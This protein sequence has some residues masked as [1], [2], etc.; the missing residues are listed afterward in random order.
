MAIQRGKRGY[1][2]S[3]RDADRKWFPRL[4]FSTLDEAKAYEKDCE[5]RAL[6]G[7]APNPKA[8]QTFHQLWLQWAAEC[9]TE[10]SE[11]WKIS[12]DQMYRDHVKPTLGALKIPEIRSRHVGAL[13]AACQAKGLGA[14]TRIHIFNLV[15]QVF[16]DA[17]EVYDYLNANPARARFKPK[18]P[19]VTRKFLEPVEA[20]RFLDH[21]RD[22]HLGP[23]FWIMTL[24]G[25]RIGE[26]QALQWKHINLAAGYLTVERQWQRKVRKFTAVKNKTDNKIPMPGELIDYLSGR[27]PL[28]ADHES[29]V[30]VG[31]ITG[32]LVHY[33]TIEDALKRLCKSGG[34]PALS[35]HELR[36][37]STE[38]WIE[39]GANQ[40]DLRR[41]LNHNSAASVAP[42]LHKTER[43]MGALSKQ[44]G[45]AGPDLKLVKA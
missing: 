37:T 29:L 27:K 22:E 31:Q 33:D 20:W 17:I 44:V 11:G 13:M 21:V 8:R 7:E 16:E 10:T 6:K 15:H 19:K 40:E 3:V 2:V 4:T 32:D 42:Y 38:I 26:T 14:Q 24:C 30:L 18:K 23:A 41:L 12:Q 43:R 39:A 25:L 5:L 28:G 1:L 36:H 34:F 45:R 9:R 35:P